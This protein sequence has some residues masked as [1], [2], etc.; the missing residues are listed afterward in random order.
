MVLDLAKYNVIVKISALFRLNDEYP[1]DRVQKERFD[2]LLE[3]Y[4]AE[5]LMFGTDFPFVMDQDFGYKGA[6]ELVRS[7]TAGDET[8]TNAVMGGTAERLFGAWGGR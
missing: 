8:V 4:G 7:W 3:V 6:V 2:K 5:R 1:F